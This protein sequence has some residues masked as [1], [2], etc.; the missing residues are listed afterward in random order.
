MSGFDAIFDRV[1]STDWFSVEYFGFDVIETWYTV[2]I[3]LH[4]ECAQPLLCLLFWVL[5]WVCVLHAMPLELIARNGD[6]FPEMLQ[7]DI[8]LCKM[9]C[10]RS[11]RSQRRWI[12][13]IST[14]SATEEVKM[15]SSIDFTWMFN[16]CSSV[17][18]S[19]KFLEM[20]ANNS[21]FSDHE[22]YYGLTLR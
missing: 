22:K 20:C 21:K 3:R 10:L 5:Y 12:F 14:P 4:L 1:R 13:C 15:F 17:A 6:I 18:H 8:I 19:F 7:G 2:E 16:S 9:T 11:R